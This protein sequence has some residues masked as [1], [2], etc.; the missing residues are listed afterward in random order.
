MHNLFEYIDELPKLPIEIED[1]IIRST[2]IN[3]N[4]FVY[5]TYENYKSYAATLELKK[6]IEPFFKNYI[7]KVQVM[8]NTLHIHQDIGRK[9]A[10]NYLINGGGL[11]VET[12]FYNNK[13]KVIQ[14]I[15]IEERRW[16]RLNVSVFHNV[17][18]LESP[19]IALTVSPQEINW[20]HK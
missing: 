17:I 18:N 13:L 2:I 9:I 6:F 4:I 8:Q 3:K 14:Q 10:Y 20:L 12:C 5:N 7:I 16:H 19:R 1:E 15:K 11:N